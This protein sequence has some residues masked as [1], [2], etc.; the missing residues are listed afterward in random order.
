MLRKS[1]KQPKKKS[2]NLTVEFD[3]DHAMDMI[4]ND[5]VNDTDGVVGS[6]SREEAVEDDFSDLDTTL[7]D[8]LD[9]F[10]TWDDDGAFK[11][12]ELELDEMESDLNELESELSEL[13]TD[14]KSLTPEQTELLKELEESSKTEEIEEEP[15]DEIQEDRIVGLNEQKPEARKIRIAG[16]YGL[17][18]RAGRMNRNRL[19]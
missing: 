19:S 13:E 4:L 18:A 6:E 5:M 15:L 2:K 7:N 16:S 9:E 8:G 11:D 10:D 12:L 14:V 1:T 17:N 3:E